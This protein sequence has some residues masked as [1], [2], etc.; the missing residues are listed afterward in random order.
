MVIKYQR[1]M[2]EGFN[3]QRVKAAAEHQRQNIAHL[4]VQFNME[5]IAH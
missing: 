5:G 3:V 2:S 1:T 4:N